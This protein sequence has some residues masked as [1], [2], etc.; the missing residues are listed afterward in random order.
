VLHVPYFS[1]RQLKLC[2]TVSLTQVGFPTNG[3]AV[4]DIDLLGRLV[5]TGDFRE[6]A[7]VTYLTSASLLAINPVETG[8]LALLDLFH[9]MCL[10]ISAER[11]ICLEFHWHLHDVFTECT[12]Y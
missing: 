1:L 2:N 12:D 3:T 11:T 7:H 5:A 6:L 4:P 10:V 9:L 8:R